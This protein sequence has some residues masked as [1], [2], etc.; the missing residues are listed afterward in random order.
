MS[1][2]KPIKEYTIEELEKLELQLWRQKHTY[3]VSLEQVGHDLG[4][5]SAELA[6]R[7]Q[8]AD[9]ATDGQTAAP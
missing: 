2:Q 6:S 9:D 1:N 8:S 3:T 7:Q 5:I 4:V